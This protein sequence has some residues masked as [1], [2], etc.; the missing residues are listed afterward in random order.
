M[1][2]LLL[3]EKL[4]TPP[5]VTAIVVVGATLPAVPVTVNV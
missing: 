1:P 5:T 2:A 4:P 3:S